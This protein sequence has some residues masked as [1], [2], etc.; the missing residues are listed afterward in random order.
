MKFELLLLGK[1][2]NKTNFGCLQKQTGRTDPKCKSRTSYRD[3]CTDGA[4][5]TRTLPFSQPMMTQLSH[6][7]VQIP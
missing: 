7:W 2:Q 6:L 1:N 5:P 3:G 4:C